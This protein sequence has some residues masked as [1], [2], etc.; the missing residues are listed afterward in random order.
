MIED[1]LKIDDNIT[2][3]IENHYLL[4]SNRSKCRHILKK[5]ELEIHDKIDFLISLH[6]VLEI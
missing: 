6:L 3:E 1:N 4:I 2:Y 5:Q